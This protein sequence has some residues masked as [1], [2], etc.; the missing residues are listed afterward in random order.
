MSAIASLFRYPV[1]GFSGESLDAVE[2]VPGQGFP[3]DR[4]FAVTDGTWRYDDNTYKPRAKMEFIAL[5]AH[6]GLSRLNLR[7]DEASGSLTCA[8]PGGRAVTVRL[9]DPQSVEG[10][11]DF[12]IDHLQLVPQGRPRLVRGRRNIFT[13]MAMVD[14][15]LHSTVSVINLATVRDLAGRMKRDAL[16]PRRFRANVYIDGVEPWDELRWVG[17]SMRLGG[18]VGHVIMPTRRCAITMIDP[19]SGTKDAGIP[20]ALVKNFGHQDLGVMI[21]VVVGGPVRPGDAV[22]VFDGSIHDT[23]EFVNLS[24]NGLDIPVYAR[25]GSP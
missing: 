20:Q 22:E 19:A 24:W 1:K 11:I 9:D 2:L 7:M 4:E 10:F 3:L 14:A 13:D 8:A 21:D 12:V 16:D 25:R 6:S 18:A 17:R 5:L 23:H 15:G